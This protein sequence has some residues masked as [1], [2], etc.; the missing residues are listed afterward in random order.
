MNLLGI[1]YGTTSVKAV[2]FDEDL[3]QLATFSE[4]YTL[5][6]KGDTVEFPAE[7]Y[8]EILESILKKVSAEHKVDAL[9]LACLKLNIE[10]K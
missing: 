2:L 1:D 6:T 4:D 8:W 3:N 5:I 7:K 9:L 10:A